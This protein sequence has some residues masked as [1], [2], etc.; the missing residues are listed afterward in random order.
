M[1]YFEGE[2]HIHVMVIPRNH[3]NLVSISDR[4]RDK[5]KEYYTDK[6]LENHFCNELSQLNNFYI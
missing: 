2:Y 6:E 4:K 5:L 1:I 3:D